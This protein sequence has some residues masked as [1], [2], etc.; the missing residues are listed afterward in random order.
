MDKIQYLVE[1]SQYS[2]E[3]SVYGACTFFGKRM[4]ISSD[5][6]RLFFIYASFIAFGSPVFAYHAV[7]FF[8]KNVLPREKRHT[9][10]SI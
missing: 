10:W 9:F 8:F 4:H 7:V 6:I 5:R 3:R 1:Q 2:I